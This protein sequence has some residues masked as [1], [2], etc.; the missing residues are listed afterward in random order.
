MR[1]EEESPTLDL[2]RTYDILQPPIPMTSLDQS[3]VSPEGAPTLRA[4]V[5]FRSENLSRRSTLSSFTSASNLV[6]PSG[7]R[8]RHGKQPSRS[9]PFYWN[10]PSQ[11]V[12][13]LEEK[14]AQ[15]KHRRERPT[16][17]YHGWK[18]ILF[19]SCECPSFLDSPSAKRSTGLNLFLI[20]IPI[21]VTGARLPATNTY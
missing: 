14:R 2:L 17:W 20:V 12:L 16:N 7:P 11:H 13:A 15:V 19:G 3:P 21:S 10:W 8:Q 4:P 1:T 18:V 5:P 9:S 6:P